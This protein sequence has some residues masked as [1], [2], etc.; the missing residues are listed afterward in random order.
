MMYSD[1]IA[2]S[3][4]KSWLKEHRRSLIAGSIGFLLSGWILHGII[5]N[6]ASRVLELFMDIVPVLSI[7]VGAPLMFLPAT[8]GTAFLIAS[9]WGVVGA[10][11][12]SSIQ[13]Q[14][15]I[16]L[17]VLVALTV[18][19]ACAFIMALIYVPT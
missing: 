11:L 8:W 14:R 10:L 17:V 1:Q 18:I 12:A 4:F 5:T 2:D 19:G 7:I 3:N 13:Q 9:M 15:R 6:N 16:G